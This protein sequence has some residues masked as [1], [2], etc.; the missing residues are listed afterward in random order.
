[1]SPAYRAPNAA[2]PPICHPH[3][4]PA[5]H[6]RRT[7][8][9]NNASGHSPPAKPR[10]VVWP[11]SHRS[12][13]HS[14]GGFAPL[15]APPRRVAGVS[16]PLMLQFPPLTRAGT[17]AVPTSAPPSALAGISDAPP[18]PAAAPPAQRL[19]RS[20]LATSRSVSRRPTRAAAPL[21]GH[22]LGPVSRPPPPAKTS[23]STRYSAKT[24][25][26]QLTSLKLSQTDPQRTR[27]HT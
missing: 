23:D 11:P 9:G 14:T 27:I 13:A 20:R 22:G 6:Q 18:R 21:P 26:D 8:P 1:M 15:D 3:H 5:R 17:T 4:G 2:I 16:R 25:S 19:H 10:P 7:T 12:P 24:K